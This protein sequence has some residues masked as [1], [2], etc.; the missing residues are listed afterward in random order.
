MFRLMGSREIDEFAGSLVR[1]FATRFPPEKNFDA[2]P[3]ARA[4]DEIC[5]RAKAYQREKRLGVYG[6]ARMGTAF[7][8]EL[9]TAGYPEDFIDAFTRQLLL[10][11]SGK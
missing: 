7:K 3:L 4:I 11:M 1:E 6:K 10:L 5:G 8:F 9:K 2:A